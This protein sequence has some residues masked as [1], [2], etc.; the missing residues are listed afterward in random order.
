MPRSLSHEISCNLITQLCW[1]K[2]YKRRSQ[3]LRSPYFVFGGS[4]A[5]T[6]IISRFISHC[7]TL[8]RLSCVYDIL[9]K[10]N[11][12]TLLINSVTL[13][14]FISSVD[15]LFYTQNPKVETYLELISSTLEAILEG[16]FY[17][18]SRSTSEIAFSTI[19][20]LVSSGYCLLNPFSNLSQVLRSRIRDRS[21]LSRPRDSAS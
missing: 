3:N 11:S 14:L 13:L 7:N 9:I 16:L 8:D 4:T 5:K 17:R 1:F 10:S 19:H 18:R 21:S 6:K 15:R 12:I 2:Y 20:N